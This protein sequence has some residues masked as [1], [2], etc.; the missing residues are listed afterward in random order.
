MAVAL[1]MDFE[2]GTAANYDAV[3]ADMD[4]QGK[5]PPGGRFHAAGPSPTGWRV[6]DV[7]DGLE[8][9]QAFAEAKIL[10]LVAKHGLA[11]PK[12]ETFHVHDER[13]GDPSALQFL[14]VVRIPDL[15]GAAFDALDSQVVP[16]GVPEHLGYHVNGKLGNGWCIVDT[17]DS[18]ASRDAFLENNIRPAVE[19]AGIRSMPSFEDM[20]VHNTITQAGARA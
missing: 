2:G 5:L 19:A 10:P 17:W 13:R 16:D 1:I 6:C 4:L 9:F 18:K 8:Q 14:Q 7:W 12:I 3:M 11:E 20:D 15:D